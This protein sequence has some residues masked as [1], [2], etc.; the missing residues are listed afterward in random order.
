MLPW[1][2]V[3]SPSGTGVDRP[4]PR[5]IGKADSQV[6]RRKCLLPQLLGPCTSLRAAGRACSGDSPGPRSAWPR[7]GLFPHFNGRRSIELLLRARHQEHI[8]K[9]R[10]T[11]QTIHCFFH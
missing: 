4:G 3:K 2:W 10:Q 8:H 1:A 11:R 6:L 5:L 9:D 7:E